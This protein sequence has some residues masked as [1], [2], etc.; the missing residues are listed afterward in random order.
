MKILLA[1]DDSEYCFSLKRYL[2][3]KNNGYEISL[4]FDG[5]EA[6]RCIEAGIYDLIILDCEM[7]YFSGID[8]LKTIKNENPQTKIVM[9]SGY[10]GIAKPFA[11][12]AGIDEFLAK[13]FALTELDKILKKY[14]AAK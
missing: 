11:K 2:L 10:S 6:K 3:K 1:D 14:G 5:E 8:L 13:P 9:V 7:P 12:S 4:A